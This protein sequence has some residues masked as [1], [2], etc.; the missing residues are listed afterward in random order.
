MQQDAGGR[1]LDL[2]L[3]IARGIGGTKA[4][5]FSSSFEEETVIDLFAEQF[6]W[7]GIGKLCTLYYD[8]LVDAGYAPETVATEMYLSGEM[9]EVAEAMIEKGFFKQLELHS[10]TSQYGQLS[11]ADRV[12]GP[13][14]EK[15][16]RQTLAALRSGDFAREWAEEQAKDKT[17]LARLKEQAFAHP[18][19][20]VERRLPWRRSD[21]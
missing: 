5:A 13:D 9:V 12:L 18:L 20:D 16:A 17:L 2:A 21:D 1:A 6:L 4:G 14:A 8:I 19:N 7:A 10:Q 11:R 15:R 3:S